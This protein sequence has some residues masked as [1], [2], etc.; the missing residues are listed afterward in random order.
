M[1]EHFARLVD[2]GAGFVPGRILLAGARTGS[3]DD[4][5]RTCLRE[6]KAFLETTSAEQI[7]EAVV[8]EPSL[9]RPLLAVLVELCH[10]G[11]LCPALLEP[12]AMVA[13]AADAGFDLRQSTF[14]STILAHELGRLRGCDLVPTTVMKATGS[15]ARKSEVHVELFVPD[16]EPHVTEAWIAESVGTHLGLSVATAEHFEEAS[17]LL[18]AAGFR[19][20]PFMNE[21]P[22]TNPA[23]GVTALYLDRAV[24]GTPLR[25]ELV[26]DDVAQA[27][28]VATRA[29]ASSI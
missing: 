8:T 24:G 4:R 16:V 7:V 26:I 21:R 15:S 22:M 9:R 18:R 13:A 25:L 27:R 29:S 12:A 23:D 10:I 5:L 17:A 2:P 3:F 20:P 14:A 6:A 28:Q 11:F 1:N 19:V